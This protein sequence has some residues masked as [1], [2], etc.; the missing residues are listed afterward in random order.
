[1]VLLLTSR[2]SKVLKPAISS[3]LYFDLA[4]HLVV[5]S[6]LVFVLIW[7]QFNVSVHFDYHWLVSAVLSLP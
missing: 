1:V 4:H 3:T 2:H 7:A 5:I 6:L